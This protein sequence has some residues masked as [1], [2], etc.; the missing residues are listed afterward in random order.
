M[1]SNRLVLVL[2]LCLIL[3]SSNAYALSIL[4]QDPHFEMY[5]NF[6]RDP[7]KIVF[8]ES[9]NTSTAT[10]ATVYV[11]YEGNSGQHVPITISF[12]TTNTVNDTLVVTPSQSNNRWPFAERLEINITGGLLAAGGTAFDGVYPVGQLFVANI[13]DDLDRMENWDPS[14]PFDFVDAFV[15]ANVLLGFNPVDPENTNPNR[16]ETIPGMGATEAW[17]WTAGRPDVIIAVV[18]DGIEGYEN[19]E[20]T[21]NFHLNRGELTPPTIGG[22]SC[23]P[24]PWDCNQDGRFNVRDYDDDPAF[25]GLGRDVNA[26]DLIDTFSDDFDADSNGFVDD[27]CGWDFYRRTNEALGVKEFPEGGHG[28]D[29]AKDAAAGAQN[30]HGDKPGYCPRCTILPIRVSDSVMSEMNT[31]GQGI[32]YAYDMGASVAIFASSSFDYN[33]EVNRLLTEV[34]EAGMVLVGVASDELGYHHSF[35][36]SCDDV[37]S[38]KSI[39]PI[40]PIDF[41]GFFPMEVFGFTETYC[42][43]WGEGVHLAGSSGAC[44]SE[45]AGNIGGAAGLIISRARDLG[46]NLSANEVKQILTMSADDIYRFCLTLTGGG[47]QRGWDAHYGYGRPNMARAFEVLGDPVNGKPTLIPPEVKLYT[48][49]WFQIVD[50]VE[51]PSI[52]VEAYLYSR[53]RNFDWELQIAPG[54]E[55]LNNQFVTIAS[56]NST[57]EIDDLIGTIDTESIFEPDWYDNPPENSF[58]FTVTLRLQASYWVAGEGT[59]LGEDRRTFAIHR[60]QDEGAGLMPGFPIDLD[61]SGEST[62]VL[63]DMDGD[64]DGRLEIVLTNSNSELVV[65]KYNESNSLFEIMDGFPIDIR[66]YT[67]LDTDSSLSTPAV[68]D[69]FGDGTPYIVLSTVAGAILV[70]DRFGNDTKGSPLLDGFPV[71]ADPADNSSTESYGHGNSFGAAPV[72]GDLDNDGVLEIIAANYDGKIYAWKPVDSDNDGEADR[73]PGFPVLAKSEAGNV[74]GNKVCHRE[75]EE[76]PPQILGTPIVGIFNPDSQDT[77]I[78]EHPSIFIGTS[79]V[80]DD[81][82]LKTARFYGIYHDGYE[83]D[84]GTA[85]LPGWPVKLTAPL[86]DA[87]PIPPVTIGIT[88]TPAM[89]RYNNRTWFGIGAVVWLPQ[90]LEFDGDNLKTHN[91]SSPV[92][93]NLLGHGSFGRLAGDDKLHYVLPTTSAIDMI[94]GWISLLRAVMVAWDMDDLS[95]P[96]MSANVEDSNWYCNASIADISGDGNAELISGTGGF[97]VHA[98]DLQGNE[99]KAWPKFTNNWSVSAPALGDVDADGFLEVILHTREGYLFGWNTKGKACKEN[100]FASDWWSFHHDEHNTGVYGKD[101]LPPKIVSDLSVTENPDGGFLLEFT[102]PGDDW[103]CGTPESYDIRYAENKTDLEDTYNFFK[104]QKIPQIDLPSPVHAGQTVSFVTNMPG[105]DLWFAI[106]TKDESGNLSHLSKPEKSST[107]SDDDDDSED[108]DDDDDNDNDDNDDEEACCG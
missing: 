61:A 49:K 30:G 81:S 19:D 105:S 24:D 14:D 77:D 23:Q 7:M 70:V 11:N 83:N 48:P 104:A 42:T 95:T 78:A 106:Q 53:G 108:D 68:G 8:D 67:G 71:F 50:P 59:I 15:N 2:M 3:L 51:T 33:G 86:A 10:D 13:P 16:P 76:F 26:Q 94:D 84:S 4:S 82:I 56:G 69:L 98:L 99:P 43:M 38:V 25:S 12:E 91:L 20:L 9:L 103:Q 58:D 1:R 5:E 45:A 92:S 27:I 63:Y 35:A 73:M 29:R 100:E 44:S 88:S 52:E 18:D 80:C 74:P 79:E 89:A 6:T 40:P 72:L 46:I 55:P 96:A 47:C 36:G 41:L 28:E 60:D 31:L 17:K 57:S 93:F 102:A 85:F 107:G 87:L 90:L 34:S 21:E 62:P 32:Q 66:N 37:I 22:T 75:D 101:T 64:P 97:T 65:F 54:K 39:F